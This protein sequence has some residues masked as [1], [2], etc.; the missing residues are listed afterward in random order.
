MNATPLNKLLGIIE[1]F[2]K[3]D[4]EMPMQR[5]ATF[6]HVCLHEGCTMLEI[7]EAV[8]QSQASASRNVAALSKWQ[9][10]RRVGPDLINAEEDPYERRRKVVTLTS[11]GQRIAASLKKLM[12]K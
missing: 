12:E 6:V 3:I 7:V 10:Q 11:K 8:G 4:P 2:R 9:R 5:A 1:E